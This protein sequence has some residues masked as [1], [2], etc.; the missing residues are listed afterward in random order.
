MRYHH[1][2]LLSPSDAAVSPSIIG[3]ATSARLSN[4]VNIAIG[5]TEK[6]S[7]PLSDFV[8]KSSSSLPDSWRNRCRC[9][10]ICEGHTSSSSDSYSRCLP[11]KMQ[12]FARYQESSR[13]NW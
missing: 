13:K 8:E 6:S 9:C 1:A 7:L 12:K 2:E 5:F 11:Q 4:K 10:Q 3:V